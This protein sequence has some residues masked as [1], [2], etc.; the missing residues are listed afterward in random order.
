MCGRSPHPHICRFISFRV[1][2]FSMPLEVQP[3]S[4]LRRAERDEHA[5]V[6]ERYGSLLRARRLLIA[7]LEDNPDRSQAVRWFARA[8]QR[9]GAIGRSAG[10]RVGF[11][12]V[13][14]VPGGIEAGLVVVT[15]AQGE[16]EWRGG[17]VLGRQGAGSQSQESQ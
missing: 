3:E 7:P 6:P 17:I 16:E 9:P 15:E 12:L 8:S 2:I 1:G 14:L 10:R 13:S 11:R 5:L 4:R